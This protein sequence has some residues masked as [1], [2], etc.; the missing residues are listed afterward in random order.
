MIP[1]SHTEY[2]ALVQRESSRVIATS[3]VNTTDDSE[4]LKQSSLSGYFRAQIT[5]QDARKY[6]QLLSRKSIVMQR[7]DR[8]LEKLSQIESQ[9]ILPKP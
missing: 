4:S 2:Y 6:N 3:E 1:P 5:K 7:K 9:L 8:L